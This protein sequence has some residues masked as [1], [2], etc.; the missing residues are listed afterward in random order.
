[1]RH[2]IIAVLLLTAAPVLADV[3]AAPSA[4]SS[5]VD[6][7]HTGVTWRVRHL[8]LSNFTAR[9]ARVGS[10]LRL[11]PVQP[12]RSTLNFPTGALLGGDWGM[13]FGTQFV[14]DRIELAHETDS[15]QE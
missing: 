12:A 3:P 13:A 8:G 6:P 11:D 4:G 1:M 7:A 9:F 5:L 2:R 14:S 10:T 15:T